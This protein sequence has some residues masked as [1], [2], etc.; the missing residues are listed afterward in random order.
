MR[1]ARASTNRSMDGWGFGEKPPN[2]LLDGMGFI[3]MV[4]LE[5]LA[6]SEKSDGLQRSRLRTEGC[7]AHGLLRCGVD[8]LFLLAVCGMPIVYGA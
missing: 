7:D 3:C 6:R 5:V 1:R 4:R 2:R 8:G